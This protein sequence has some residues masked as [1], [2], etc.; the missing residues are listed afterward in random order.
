MAE[1]YIQ[2]RVPVL[3]GPQ[4]SLEEWCRSLNGLTQLEKF[5]ELGTLMYG[6]PAQGPSIVSSIDFDK[7]EEFFAVGGVTSQLKVYEYSSVVTRPVSVHYPVQ[8]LTCASKI[9][10]VSYNNFLKNSIAS[11]DYDGTVVI[12][13]ICVGRHLRQWREHEKRCWSV[14]CNHFDPKIVASGSDDFKIKIWVCDMP[15]S[16]GVV[17]TEANVCS[18]RIHPASRYHLAYGCADQKVHYYDLRDLRQPLCVFDGHK[19]AVSYCQFLNDRELVSLST[20]NE[21]KL[22][23]INTGRC[24]K[25]YRGHKN[26]KQFV[27]LTVKG[28]HIVCGSENNSLYCYYKDVSKYIMMYRFNMSQSLLPD[29][30]EPSDNPDARFVSAVCWKRRSNILLAANSHGYIKVLEAV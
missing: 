26:D 2:A 17:N 24:L 22:W 28:N 16:A 15:H 18:V 14:H 8:D 19:K 20:D 25:T 23:D 12:S 11:C 21:I 6:D 3:S 4:S 10:S 9:S 27:G 29:T 30:M 13:D 5:R 1:N 7:D